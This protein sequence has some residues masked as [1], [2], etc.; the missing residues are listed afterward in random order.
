MSRSTLIALTLVVSALCESSLAASVTFV[1]P[2]RSNEV[3]WV[4]AS[5]G[6]Q[7]AADS[8]GMKL[9]IRYAERSP[10]KIIEI[11]K[12]VAAAKQTDYLIFP[13][14]YALGGEVLKIT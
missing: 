8:L 10:E 1:N 3:F 4:T 9:D 5:R 7:M 2:G 12:E 14:E 6:M 13:N 11:V